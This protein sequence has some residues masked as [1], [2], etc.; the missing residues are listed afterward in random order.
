MEREN[1]QF[2]MTA[3]AFIEE[4]INAVVSMADMCSTCVAKTSNIH[5][6][7]LVHCCPPLLAKF[8][9]WMCAAHQQGSISMNTLQPSLAP[10]LRMQ[11]WSDMCCLGLKQTGSCV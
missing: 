10:L 7:Q 11:P 9:A 6:P 3:S 5:I 1:V 2:C 4:Q 8:I